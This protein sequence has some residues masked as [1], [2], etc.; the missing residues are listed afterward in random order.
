MDQGK[1]KGRYGIVFVIVG[2][3]QLL[4]LGHWYR[5]TRNP[6]GANHWMS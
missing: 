6:A 4:I 3:G 2:I 5:E 1:K